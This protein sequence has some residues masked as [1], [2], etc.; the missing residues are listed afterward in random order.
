M[1][2]LSTMS[3]PE[4]VYRLASGQVAQGWRATF[5]HVLGKMGSPR[6]SSLA[7]PMKISKIEHPR[8]TS[9]GEV[10]RGARAPHPPIH[11]RAGS[12]TTR[13]R[14]SRHARAPDSTSRRELAGRRALADACR[15]RRSPSRIAAHAAARTRSFTCAARTPCSSRSSGPI[16]TSSEVLIMSDVEPAM[17]HRQRFERRKFRKPRTDGYDVEV[18]RR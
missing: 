3:I 8:L 10:P 1:I 7:E 16:G 18:G 11:A 2:V 17:S 9:E 12:P 6:P 15:T 13:A 14:P 4:P 5:S